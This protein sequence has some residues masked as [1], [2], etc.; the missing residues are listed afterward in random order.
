MIRSFK[1]K[2]Q[3]LSRYV[4][5]FNIFDRECD[6]NINFPAFPHVGAGLAL[7]KNAVI[8]IKGRHMNIFPTPSIHS[9]I[10]VVGK[11][12]SPVVITYNGY[13]DEISVNFAPLGINYFFT[14]DYRS[15]AP[16]NFQH[17]WDK[18]WID[19]MPKIFASNDPNDK[20]NIFEQF[21]SS[22]FR[23]RNLDQLQQAVDLFMDP[24]NDYK[25][26]DV[27]E[28][29]GMNEK[30]MRRKFIRFVGCSPVQFK[31]IV[32]FRQAIDINRKNQKSLNLTELGY[33][34]RFYDSSHFIK[35]Y[36]LLAGINPKFFFSRVSFLGNS[37][38]PY[39]F[40]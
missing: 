15:L 8:K 35:E 10:V 29:T 21:L 33:E 9:S 20:L 14:D 30:T 27:A 6:L 31:R 34:S 38:Y 11:Y 1:P 4:R 36:K 40:W 2:S 7:F 39:F 3:F 16:E 28:M 25:V 32:R 5:N 17:V 12:T 19:F 24:E 18:T 22:R 37:E 13:V 26:M 23:E